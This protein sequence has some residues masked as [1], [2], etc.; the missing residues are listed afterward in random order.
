[1][2]CKKTQFTLLIRRHH[3]RNCGAVV[4]GPCSPKKFLLPS[5]SKPQRVCLDCYDNLSSMNNQQVSYERY[6]MTTMSHGKFSLPRFRTKQTR[7]LLSRKP[8]SPP[9]V[10]HQTKMTVKIQTNNTKRWVGDAVT[11]L[12]ALTSEKVAGRVAAAVD[13]KLRKLNFPTRFTNDSIDRSVSISFL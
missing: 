1:M 13:G 6:L 8:Q 3:C 2:C 11:F 5:G 12:F 7:T 10:N 9:A 4:C